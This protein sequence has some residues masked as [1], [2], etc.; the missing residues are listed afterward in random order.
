MYITDNKNKGNLQLTNK[1]VYTVAFFCKG[2]FFLK[3]ASF[4]NSLYSTRKKERVDKIFSWK[5]V[6]KKYLIGKSV[7]KIKF[8]LSVL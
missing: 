2:F 5:F 4:Y 1:Q 8:Y 6:E 7:F 3:S